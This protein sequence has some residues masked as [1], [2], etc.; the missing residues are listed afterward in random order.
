MG[1]CVMIAWGLFEQERRNGRVVM[2]YL[3]GLAMTAYFAN[4]YLGYAI[5][6]GEPVNILETFC[7]TEHNYMNMLFLTLGWML[8][9]AD[10][11]FVKKNTYLLLYRCGRRRWNAGMLLYLLGQAFLYTA[12]LAA[13]TVILSSSHGFAGSIWS[14][15]AYF[16]AMNWGDDIAAKYHVGFSQVMMMSTMTVPQ[17][18]VVSFLFLYLYLA[19]LGV[20]LY[21]CSLQL[22]G[23]WGAVIMLGLHLLGYLQIMKGDTRLSLLARAVPGNFMDKTLRYWNSAAIFLG[24]IAVAGVLS[25][26]LVKKADFNTGKGEICDE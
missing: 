26:I 22:S 23:I 21:A 24:L 7:V 19:L 1:R 15:P 17:A 3:F 6:T 5:E 11:P 25:A 10:A 20:L 8:V 13:F 9:I 12:C 2:G 18:F 16:L 4:N 14:S